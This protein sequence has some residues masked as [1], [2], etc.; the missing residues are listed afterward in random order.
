MNTSKLTI[1]QMKHWLR[2]A[3]KVADNSDNL[4]QVVAADLLRS[5]GMPTDHEIPDDKAE[6]EASI[7]GLE[8]F[9]IDCSREQ[10][11]LC[12]ITNNGTQCDCGEDMAVDCQCHAGTH[13]F[14][15]THSETIGLIIADSQ[16]NDPAL[17]SF[18]FNSVSCQ[19]MEFAAIY[20]YQVI[21]RFLAAELGFHSTL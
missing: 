20:C 18:N 7:N 5:A 11:V 16:E 9:F 3:I 15:K 21:T 4:T 14:Y 6:L 10:F 2:C 13:G 17:N 8:A 19:D 12:L 1:E